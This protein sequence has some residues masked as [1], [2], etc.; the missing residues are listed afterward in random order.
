MSERTNRR[1][2]IVDAAAALFKEQ[3]YTATSIRQI[4]DQVGCT[5]AALYYHFKDGKRA[6][7]QAVLEDH[8]PSLMAILQGCEAAESLHELII[9]IGKN[10]SRAVNKEN[11]DNFRWILAEFPRMSA[12]ERAAVHS[13]HLEFEQLLAVQVERFV[14]DS[15]LARKIAWTMVCA[16]FGFGQLFFN[17]EMDKLVDFTPKDLTEVMAMALPAVINMC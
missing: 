8:A 10:L 5:E 13:K 12:E 2:L 9:C 11:L 16:G 1:E 4:A 15:A 14:E 7:L 3:G 6:L 17:L